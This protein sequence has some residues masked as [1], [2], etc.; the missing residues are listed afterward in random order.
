MPIELQ[1]NVP[2]QMLEERLQPVEF[3]VDFLVQGQ[4]LLL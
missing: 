2:E 3:M 4:P 1:E